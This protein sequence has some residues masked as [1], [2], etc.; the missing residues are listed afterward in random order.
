MRSKHIFEHRNWNCYLWTTWKI[1]LSSQA[2][3]VRNRI[4]I[5]NPEGSGS[6]TRKDPVSEASLI[7]QTCSRN[8]FAGDGEWWTFLY[9]KVGYESGLIWMFGFGIKKT[10]VIKHREK[11]LCHLVTLAA[12]H[13]HFWLQRHPEQRRDQRW[14]SWSAFL[15]D[16]S[17]HKLESTQTR[18]FV[19]FSTFI[20][21]FFKMLFT[22]DSSFYDLRIFLYVFLKQ[23]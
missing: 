19:W 16:V 3:R 7:C 20:F 11:K 15:V 22:K 12:W 13:L 1:K 23:E 5:L 17:G 10:Y 2:L 4:R 21:L 8:N 9:L 14:N 18:V 6:L